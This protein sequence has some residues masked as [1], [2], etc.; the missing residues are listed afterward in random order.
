MRPSPD[1]STVQI[2]ILRR[3]YHGGRFATCDAAPDTDEIRPP[4]DD[5]AI[6]SR[7]PE[8]TIED[9]PIE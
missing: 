1:V 9:H 6:Y 8:E 7:Q 2:A 5:R 4:G 3:D